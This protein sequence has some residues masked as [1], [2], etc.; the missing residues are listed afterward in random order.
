LQP[1]DFRQWWKKSNGNHQIFPS[2]LTPA[3]FDKYRKAYRYKHFRDFIPAI[4]ADE[5]LKDTDE[6][7]QFQPGVDEFNSQ[8]ESNW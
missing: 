1:L 8:E 2:I 3:V 6:W 7:R 4:W 5:T